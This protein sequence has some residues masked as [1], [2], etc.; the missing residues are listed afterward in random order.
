MVQVIQGSE[1]NIIALT[2]TGEI[3]N[4][5]FVDNGLLRKPSFQ[6]RR[7]PSPLKTE[8]ELPQAKELTEK[9]LSDM[10]EQMQKQMGTQKPEV[11]KKKRWW[12]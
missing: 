7:L 12:S 6:W 5:Y 11:K 10:R 2:A 1:Q 3:Y 8:Y 9:E 4:G